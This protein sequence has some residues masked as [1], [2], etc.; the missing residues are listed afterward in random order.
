L[1]GGA[2]VGRRFTARIAHTLMKKAMTRPSNGGASAKR[3]ADAELP[4]SYKNLSA[5][6]L[7]FSSS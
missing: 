1:L 7:T 5:T 4:R 3:S 2:F 6:R